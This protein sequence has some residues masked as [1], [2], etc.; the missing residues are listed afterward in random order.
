M[1]VAPFGQRLLAISGSFPEGTFSVERLAG[2]E[3][4]G[5]CFGFDVTLLSDSP[6]VDIAKLVG[7]TVTVTIDRGPIDPRFI[8]GFVTRAALVGTFDRHA[9]YVIHVAPWLF[10]LSGRVNNRIFQKQSVPAIAKALFREHGFADFE[11]QL[12]GDYPDREFVVQH[13]ESNLAFVSRLLEKVGIY[14][15]F[16]HEQG[17][18]VLVLADSPAAHKTVTGSETIP[19]HPEGSATPQAGEQVNRWEMVMQWR[20]NSVTSSDFDFERPR[21]DLTARAQTTALFKQSEL[22]VFDY[23]AGYTKQSDVDAFVRARLIGMIGDAATCTAAGDVQGLGA[24]DLFTL[25]DFPTED[26]NKQYLVVDG[27]YDAVN[28][29]HQTGGHDDA[30]SFHSTFTLID[31]AQTYRPHLATPVPRVEGPQTAIVVGESGEEITT[32]KYGRVK[33][34]FHWD[35]EGKHDQDSSCW[36]RVAQVWAGQGWGAMHIPRIGQEVIVEFLEGDPDRPIITGRVYNADNMPPYTLP[37]NKTQSG[38]KSRSTIG[39]APSNFNEI[40]FED[41]KGSEELHLQAEKD[42]S[43]KVKHDRSA[44]VGADDSISVGGDRSVTVTGNLSV[45]VKGSGKSPNHSN[46]DVTGKHH[47]KASDTIEIEAPTH[48]KL[49]CGGSSILI[50]P[51]KITLLSGGQAQLVLDANVLAQSNAGSKVVLDANALTKAST[52]GSVTVDANVKSQSAGSRM[53]L[54]DSNNNVTIDGTKIQATG[55]AQVTIAAG[56][57]SIKSDA[58]GVEISGA[59]VKING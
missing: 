17:R 55:Q 48:I 36:V 15:F 9:R 23:P 50:E 45:T 14:Y 58:G 40:R 22:E 42:F 7:D 26:Q 25:S 5:Q 34:Q 43:Q 2:R 32:D 44:D 41:K 16:R 12:S 21:A 3:G 35:R 49:T 46:L 57:G 59:I 38:I 19:F 20:V 27:W 52:G 6:T 29:T 13:R 56:S 30:G 10:L 8:H 4:L 24:G 37:D 53:V 33:V 11:D 31:A 51:D 54:V 47:V 18:H 1:S 39:G 28:N